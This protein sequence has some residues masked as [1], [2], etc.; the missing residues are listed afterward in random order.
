VD[1]WACLGGVDKE[2]NHDTSGESSPTRS[3][4]S[5]VIKRWSFSV[6]PNQTVVMK[7]ENHNKLIILR[8]PRTQ[9]STVTAKR[10]RKH[11]NVCL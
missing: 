9:K 8:D 2:N 3:S 4:C 1:P 5:I 6:R 10:A 7:I 11:E